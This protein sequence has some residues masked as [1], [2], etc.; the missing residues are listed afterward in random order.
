MHA[1]EPQRSSGDS[2]RQTPVR[3]ART[4]PLPGT[5]ATAPGAGALLALQRAAGNAAV[6]RA[7]EQERHEHGPGCGHGEA[8]GTQVQRSAVHDVL[9]GAGSPLADPV[10][11]EMEARLGQDFSDV[12]VHQGTEARRSAGEIGARAYTSGNHVVL[13]EG[14]GDKHT[15]AHELT[16]V[17]QQR[18]GPVAGTDDGGGSGCR[19][20]AT[21]SS[22]RPR[23]TRPGSWRRRRR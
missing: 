23:R 5:Q 6:L 10:R 14:G 18:Q 3:R 15:L 9:R 19:I 16:H 7:M 13:G 4:G 8:P 12:R 1:H 17:I 21:V 2:R 11:Q 22:G 20:L